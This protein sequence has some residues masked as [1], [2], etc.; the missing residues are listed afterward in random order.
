MGGIDTISSMILGFPTETSKEFAETLEFLKE[1]ADAFGM[2]TPALFG[3]DELLGEWDRYSLVPT[4]H[5]TFWRTCDGTNT[6]PERLERL[7]RFM[8]VARAHGIDAQFEA[9]VSADAMPEF[10]AK[11]LTQY[12][13]WE[14]TY[15]LPR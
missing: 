1:Y 13:S 6:L 2:V 9:K 7:Q 15:A 11:I 12:Q 8:D 3:I 14:K 5:T 4:E 10:C